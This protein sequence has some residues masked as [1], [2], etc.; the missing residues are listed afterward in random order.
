MAYETKELSGSMFKNDDK[1]E[2]THADF[3]GSAKIDG[4]EY[5]VNAWVKVYE[6]DGEKRKYFSLGFKPK[7]P[8]APKAPEKPSRTGGVEQMS[9]DIPF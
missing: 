7:K 9:D 3:N 1:A 8:A 4:K 6:K 5:W 2:E